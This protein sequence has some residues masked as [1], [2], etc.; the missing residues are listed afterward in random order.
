MA[1][2]GKDASE[3]D[4]YVERGRVVFTAAY[5]LRRGKCCGNSCRHCPYRREVLA[6]DEHGYAPMETLIGHW[7]P[8]VES[9]EPLQ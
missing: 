4:Y 3:R 5:L 1:T 6:T 2:G 9:C 7:V 8:G